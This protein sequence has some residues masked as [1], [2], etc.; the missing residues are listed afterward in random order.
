[1]LVILADAYSTGTN[2]DSFSRGEKN[3]ALSL[4]SF[5][6]CRLERK[7]NVFLLDEAHSNTIC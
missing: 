6:S 2:N 4:E 7:E 1:M 3:N 5:Y